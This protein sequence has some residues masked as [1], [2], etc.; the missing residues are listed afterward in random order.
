MNRSWRELEPIRPLYST[1]LAAQLIGACIGLAVHGT[2]NPGGAIW[3]GGALATFPGFLLGLPIQHKLRP[4]SLAS[5]RLMIV[6]LGVLALAITA[7]PLFVPL[8][9]MG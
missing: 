7:A 5:N 2:A 9:K 3:L 1:V 6:V 8:G 4:G